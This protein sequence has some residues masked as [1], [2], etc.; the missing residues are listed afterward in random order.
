MVDPAPPGRY[1]GGMGQIIKSKKPTPK[2]FTPKPIPLPDPKALPKS[3][4]KPKHVVSS[5]PKPRPIGSPM[6]HQERKCA[7]ELLAICRGSIARARDVLAQTQKGKPTAEEL[8]GTKWKQKVDAA[9]EWGAGRR[10]C[11]YREAY[12]HW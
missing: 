3:T 12:R 10:T 4:A 9:L 11:S 5:P 8:Q 1:I 6:T 7:K 2:P